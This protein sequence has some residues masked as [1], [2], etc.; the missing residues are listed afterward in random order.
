MSVRALAV[1]GFADAHCERVKAGSAI[2]VAGSSRP[3]A[4][5]R[6]NHCAVESTTKTAGA[7][8]E[9][10]F[11]LMAELSLRAVRSSLR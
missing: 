7:T 3:R 10:L 2:V 9:G 6:A 8:E 11:A 4:P 5:P 1:H